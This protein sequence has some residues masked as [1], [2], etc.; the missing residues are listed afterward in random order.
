VSRQLAREATF[1]AHHLNVENVFCWL[2]T[3]DQI[4]DGVHTITAVGHDGMAVNIIVK[5]TAQAYNEAHGLAVEQVHMAYLGKLLTRFRYEEI[6][7]EY[8]DVG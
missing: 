6:S 2:P 3:F 1:W 8:R 5:N 7:S 4:C